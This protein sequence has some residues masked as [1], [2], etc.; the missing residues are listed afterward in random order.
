MSIWKTILELK[1]L[2]GALDKK[3][4]P[5]V[6]DLITLLHL[7]VTGGLR[8]VSCVI[9]STKAS[10]DLNRIEAREHSRDGAICS[11]EKLST[12]KLNNFL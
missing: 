4:K 9:S 12:G 11:E 2:S 10:S 1:W 8:L 6:I 5:Y 7:V 3:T